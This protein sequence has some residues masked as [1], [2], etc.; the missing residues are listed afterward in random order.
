[1]AGFQVAIHGRF[2]GVHRGSGRSGEFVAP[3]F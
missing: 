2:S 3:K 1:L